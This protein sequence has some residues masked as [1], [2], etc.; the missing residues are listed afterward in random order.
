MP[1]TPRISWRVN[2]V[3]KWIQRID[4]KT[5]VPCLSVVVQYMIM[6]ACCCLCR[7]PV[8]TDHRR[9]KKLH[10][11]SC[12]TA[13]TVLREVSSVPLEALVETRDQSAVLCYSCEK[14][15]NNIQ[16]LTAKVE[17][18]RADVRG[19][20]SA[21]QSVR[22]EKRQRPAP[23]IDGQELP[24]TKHTRIE[25]ADSVPST[26]LPSTSEPGSGVPTSAQ[27]TSPAD[28]Q[29]QLPSTSAAVEPAVQAP[30]P[31]IQVHVATY[32][33]F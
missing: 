10:G 20:V 13:R 29:L 2:W 19:K 16:S 18:L 12:T 24:P 31:R 26:V 14:I 22:A 1:N 11:A 17:T 9:R 8:S 33:K 7:D 5:R 3:F 27:V 21:L 23:E 25:N 30:S 15:L 28:N 4:V 32:Y 6:A